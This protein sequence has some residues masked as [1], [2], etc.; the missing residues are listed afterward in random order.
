MNHLYKHQTFVLMGKI[1]YKNTDIPG[2][3][4]YPCSPSPLPA[5]YV[6]CPPPA[7]AGP[8]AAPSSAPAA[9]RASR[10]AEL[11]GRLAPGHC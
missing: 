1:G 2:Y 7:C 4:A 3:W 5:P 9:P 6:A 10:P 8:V 11:A